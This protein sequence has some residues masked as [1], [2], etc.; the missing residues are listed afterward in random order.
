MSARLLLV[1]E[2]PV[3]PADAEQA[4]KAWLGQ[5]TARP[6]GARLYR[7]AE[8]T[9]T[10]LELRPLAGLE[11]LIALRE[12]WRELW[13]AVAPYAAGDF[14][15]QVQEF[16]E[17]PKD[18]DDDLPATPYV[19]LRRVEVKPPVLAD[20][21]EWRDRTI[22]ETVRAAPESEIFLAYHSLLS[23][24]PGVLFVAGFS[25]EPTQHNG[26]FKTPAYESILEE[27][28]E[29]YIVPVGGQ[30]GLFTKTYARVE[31]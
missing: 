27:V 6:S 16:V 9:D 14:R 7:S 13:D 29:K 8:G 17:A 28:R 1:T 26:V 24:E 30:G 18:T 31:D 15:R 5:H 3:R 25:C 10:L 12:E 19:Q 23:T 2:V 20:Y 4:A 22:F 11:E 21:R